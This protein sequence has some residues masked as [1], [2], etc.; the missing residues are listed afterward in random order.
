MPWKGAAL[1]LHKLSTLMFCLPTGPEA[2]LPSD[3][4]LKPWAKT[5]PLSFTFILSSILSQ[6]QKAD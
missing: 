2:L 1:Q 3:H 5:N 4:G 6:Q